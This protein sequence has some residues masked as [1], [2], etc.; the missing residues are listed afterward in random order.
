MKLSKFS[1]NIDLLKIIALLLMTLDHTAKIFPNIKFAEF[2]YFLG[3][4]SLPLFA[5]I[6]MYHLQSK[7]IYKKYLLR[8]GVWGGITYLALLPFY[9]CG[10][11]MKL[12]PFNILF[13]FFACVLALALDDVGN[14]KIKNIFLRKM[15]ILL[16]Y[17][18][19]LALVCRLS[20]FAFIYIVLIFYYFRKPTF[21]NVVITALFGFIANLGGVL[22]V[23]AVVATLLAMNIDYKAEHKRL[24]KKWYLFYL[25]YPLHLVLLLLIKMYA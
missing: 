14:K 11:D 9:Y 6:L 23:V 24:I 22:G 2:F 1:I 16:S 25:Y 5:F 4:F 13:M 21:L 20:I 8:L 17:V 3:R 15:F 18:F 7:Q 10:V 19:C 12:V